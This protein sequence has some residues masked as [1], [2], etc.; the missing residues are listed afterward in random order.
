M[1]VS[2]TSV[3]TDFVLDF[4]AFRDTLTYPSL[5]T[6]TASFSAFVTLVDYFPNITTLR[7]RSFELEPDGGPVPSL[8]RPL[9]GKL[10]VREV[11]A[12]RLSSSVGS[13]SWTWSMGIW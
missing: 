10:Y 4:S 2:N 5:E 12:S 6:F 8:S 7:L 13:P 3:K 11:R 1:S 9:R